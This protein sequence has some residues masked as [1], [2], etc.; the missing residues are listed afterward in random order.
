MESGTFKGGTDAPDF[1]ATLT[2][3]LRTPLTGVLG[4]LELAL[5]DATLRG[6]QRRHIEAARTCGE[7]MRRMLDAVPAAPLR[8]PADRSA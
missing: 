8:S 3:D 2:H 7:R 6:D 4:F 5:E 1:L